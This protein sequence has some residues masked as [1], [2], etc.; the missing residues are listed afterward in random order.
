VSRSPTPLRCLVL[1][2]AALAA[3][4]AAAQAPAKTAA[5]AKKPPPAPKAGTRKVIRLD[6]LTVE[7]RIQKPEAFYVLPRSSLSFDELQKTES[8]VPLIDK[9]AQKEPL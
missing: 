2:L 3:G 1:V 6:T 4:P 7:G 8:F 5:P 9:S